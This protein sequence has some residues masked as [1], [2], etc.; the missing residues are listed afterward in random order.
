MVELAG[1][2]E[3]VGERGDLPPHPAPAVVLDL[4]FGVIWYRV[5][6]TRRKLDKALVDDL[7]RV[8][9]PTSPVA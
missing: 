9:S 3:E 4:V 2:G 5:L 8:L 6:A 1:P 7:I